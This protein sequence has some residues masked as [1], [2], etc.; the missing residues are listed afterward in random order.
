MQ[1]NSLSAEK[2]CPDRDLDKI[3]FFYTVYRPSSSLVIVEDVAN[4]NDTFSM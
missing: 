2:V 4:T 3:F 1:L